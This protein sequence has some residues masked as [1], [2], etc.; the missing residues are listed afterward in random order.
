MAPKCTGICGAL[1]TKPPSGP[2]TAQLKS[3]RSLMF[4]EMAVN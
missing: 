3:K 1:A 2:K 4:V